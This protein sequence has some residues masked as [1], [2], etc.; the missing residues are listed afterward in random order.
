MLESR[1]EYP[2]LVSGKRAGNIRAV[3][4]STKR[5][6]ISVLSERKGRKYPCFVDG[7]KAGNIRAFGES[8][9]REYSYCSGIRSDLVLWLCAGSFYTSRL[10]V[11]V[12]V[13]RS[14][15]RLSRL[16]LNGTLGTMCAWCR[17]GH[18]ALFICV[19]LILVTLMGIITH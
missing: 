18:L 15:L 19:P 16:T 14:G 6:G 8:R 12:V 7:K 1:P 9:S 10:G 2:C 4:V 11:R 13:A 5:P 3:G 17:R